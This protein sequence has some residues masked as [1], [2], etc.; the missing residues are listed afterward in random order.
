MLLPFLFQLL[1]FSLGNVRF[2]SCAKGKAKGFFILSWPV[3]Q[4]LEE[5]MSVAL[6]T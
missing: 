3:S 1:K 2:P 6:G 4:G 5:N